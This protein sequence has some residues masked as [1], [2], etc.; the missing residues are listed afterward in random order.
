VQSATGVYSLQA[1]VIGITRGRIIKQSKSL[2]YT[3]HSDIS[4]NMVVVVMTP[5]FLLKF[6]WKYYRRRLK[7][8][9]GIKN[10]PIEVSKIVHMDV[11]ME[12]IF[13]GEK[14]AIPCVVLGY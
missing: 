12:V 2:F 5:C 9:S 3:I 7:N 1:R 11:E 10:R 6:F 13:C 8:S 4:K 14:L